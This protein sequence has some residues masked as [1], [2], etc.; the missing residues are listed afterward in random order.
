MQL[1]IYVYTTYALLVSVQMLMEER[2]LSFQAHQISSVD[3]SVLLVH[4][5][6]IS[7]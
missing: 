6:T 1:L 7:T 5:V 4:C 2:L 3:D